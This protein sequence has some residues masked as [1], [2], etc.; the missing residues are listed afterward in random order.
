MEILRLVLVFLHFLGMAGLIGGFLVLV[1]APASGERGAKTMLYSGLTQLVTG[2]ALVGLLPPNEFDH[3]KIGA[4]S[5]L[6]LAVVVCVI[7][8]QRRKGGA[9]G[10]LRA[11]VLLTVANVAVAVFWTTP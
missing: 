4:K 11:A 5:A 7:L 3:N 1:F 6:A 8:A 2:I 9:R 10:L